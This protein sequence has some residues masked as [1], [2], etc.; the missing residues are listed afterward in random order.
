MTLGE[1][2]W[3]E[4]KKRVSL[5]DGAY[6]VPCSLGGGAQPGYDGKGWLMARLRRNEE[7]SVVER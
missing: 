4:G 7:I 1:L 2:G 6:L 3:V 5:Y